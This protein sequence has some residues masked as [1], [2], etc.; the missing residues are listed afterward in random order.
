MSIT[1]LNLV[2]KVNYILRDA[3]NHC[4]LCPRVCGAD[5]SGGTCGYCRALVEPR[6]YSHLAHHGE[7]PPISGTKGSGTIFFS[8]CNMKC[9]YCQNYYF[10][11]LDQGNTVTIE[12]LAEIMLGIEKKGCHNINLVTPT[13][14]VPQILMALE[15]ALGKGLSLPIVYNS[16]GYELAETI[17]LLDGIVDIYLPDMRYADNQMAKKYS[18]ADRYV[19][20]NRSAILEMHRQAGDLVMDDKGIAQKGMII[21]LLAL[22]GQIS[23]TKSSLAFISQ[24]LGIHTYLSIMSQYYPTFRAYDYTE[25][26]HAVTNREYTNIVDEVHLLGLN[27]GWIQEAPENIDPKFFGTNIRPKKDYE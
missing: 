11:Q 18:D 1:K 26:S 23:G 8:H 22:P 10:S 16:S 14:Y 21:R 19:E 4:S 20:S 7:E 6:I 17:K 3:L 24:R 5:R 12:E 25:I 15:I 9:V 2:K 13:H 27:N